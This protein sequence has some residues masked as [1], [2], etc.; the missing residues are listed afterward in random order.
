MTSRQTWLS[1]MFALAVALWIIFIHCRVSDLE[2]D[3]VK[4][5]ADLAQVQRT[6][7]NDFSLA[8][9]YCGSRNLPGATEHWCT[10][11]WV[12]KKEKEAR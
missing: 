9:L 11:L 10:E 7:P 5:K 1:I 8:N 12:D 4:V 6:R 2:R 3:M